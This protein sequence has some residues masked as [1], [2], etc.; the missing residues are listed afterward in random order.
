MKRL[1]QRLRRLWCRHK[2]VRAQ[3]ATVALWGEA[4]LTHCEVRCPR[5]GAMVTVRFTRP[6]CHADPPAWADLEAARTALNEPGER[7]PYGWLRRELKREK[8]E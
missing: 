8:G 3:A 1:L 5:C 2:G 4:R 6:S 7:V